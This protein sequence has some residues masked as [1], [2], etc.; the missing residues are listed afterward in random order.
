MLDETHISSFI[1]N[2][3]PPHLQAV[4]SSLTR[5]NTIEIAC[6]DSDSGKIVIVIE[7][8]SLNSV[9]RC[10][11]QIKFW[12]GVMSVTLIYHHAEHSQ[13]LEESII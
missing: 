1:I 9:N 4:C 6:L 11:E 12:Q 5:I 7:A 13:R 8:C 3:N 10:I 2:T